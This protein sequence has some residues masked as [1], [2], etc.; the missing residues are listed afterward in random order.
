MIFF[1][2]NLAVLDVLTAWK[3]QVET[4]IAIDHK[5]FGCFVKVGSQYAALPGLK[6]CVNQGYR[7]IF[8]SVS[9][10]LALKAHTTM[11]G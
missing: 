10:V 1:L 8:A 4:I 11:S 2:L 5:P 3:D 7:G 9:R 6:L